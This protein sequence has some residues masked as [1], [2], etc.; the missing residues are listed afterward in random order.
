V[1]WTNN[2]SSV[3]TVTSAKNSTFEDANTTTVTSDFPVFDSDYMNTGEKYSYNFTQPGRFDYFD[4]NDDS[5]KGTVF[6]KQAPKG[7]PS[8]QDTNTLSLTLQSPQNNNLN[9]TALSL[10]NNNNAS[11][12]NTNINNT[13]SLDNITNIGKSSTIFNKGIL[14]QIIHSLSQMIKS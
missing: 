3:H 10:S 1:V 12:N 7:T 2:H 8:G 11:L 13:G 6:M 14:S 4:K 5:L 9:N